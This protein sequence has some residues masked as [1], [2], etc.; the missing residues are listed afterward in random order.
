MKGLL[1]KDFMLM[2][3]QKN[4]FLLIAVIT[5]WICGFSD[6]VSFTSGFTSGFLTFVVSMF[7]LSTISYDEFDNGNAFLF[8]LPITRRGYVVAK[9]CFGLLLVCSSWILSTLMIIAAVLL[10]GKSL[11][12]DFMMNV[13]LVL[14]VILIMLAIMLPFQFKFGGEK[15]RIAIIA[16]VGLLFVL[17]NIVAKAARLLHI[18]LV[19][20]FNNLPTL[21]MGMWVAV[22]IAAVVISLSVSMKISVS[23]VNKK[24]F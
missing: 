20:I 4:F 6:D 3:V 7:A 12:I 9:Y 17:G 18:D 8:S 10:K 15:G 19:A 14:P 2:K 16:T 1:I 11:S 5:I 13:F 22:I 23:I 24:E 21:S